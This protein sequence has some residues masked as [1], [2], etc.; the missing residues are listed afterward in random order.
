MDTESKSR[1][2]LLEELEVLRR[3]VAELEAR[4]LDRDR[5]SDRVDLFRRLVEHSLGL[6]CVHDLDGN[7]LFVNTAAAQ[8]LG[9]RPE[10][11]VGWNLRT[12]LPPSVENQFDAYLERIRNNSVDGGLMRLVAK[13]GTERIWLYRNVLYEE[14]GKPPR[15]LGHAQD[16]TER[17]HAQQ[18]LKESEQRFRLLADTAPVL[19]WM[20]DPSGGCAFL[21]QPWLDFTGGALAEQ[22]GVGWT[23]SIHPGDR[24]RF[25]AVYREAVAARTPLQAEF[26]LRRADGEY[27]WV[28]ASGVPRIEADGAFAGLIGSCVDITETR[29]AR[30]VLQAARDELAALVARRTAELEQSNEQLR[31]EMRHRAQIE[32]EVARARRIESLGVLAGGIA[33]EFNNLLTV[34]VGRSQLMLERFPP[35]EPARRD[36][37][38]IQRMTDRAAALTQQL[39]AFGGM[40]VVQPR[41]VNLNKLVAG[42]SLSTVIGERIELTLRL[43]ETLRRAS[44]DPGQLQRV[45]LHLVQN[46]CDA[47]PDGGQLVLETANVD[48]DEAF[49]QTQP[50]A[51]P[52]PHVRL[53]IRD[54][55]AGMDEATRSHVFEPFSTATRG[56]GSELSLAAVYGITKQH[57]GYI[58][59][60]SEPDRGTAFL[61]YL[62]AAGEAGSPAVGMPSRGPRGLGG[63]ETVLLVEDEEDVR[64]LLR[65]I[66]QLHGYR[67]IEVNDPE[68]ALSLVERRPEPIHLVL[69]DVVMGRMSGPGL[70]DRL[71]AVRPGV[72]VLWM[73]GYTAEALRGQGELDAGVALLKKPFTVMS[74]L[75]KVREVLGGA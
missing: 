66:L 55:G 62:P 23:E 41:L 70:A 18:A 17:I 1:D 35:A 52:G 58:A 26:R 21:N 45:I 33:H 38:L 6:M 48:L 22:V 13:Y 39:L 47:M 73:S 44:V 14:A 16:V 63:T 72:K 59:V 30:E 15:V 19:I 65:D 28:L 8:I 36:V 31:A 60:E 12:F 9:F 4:E 11:G 56:V 24:D 25:V 34:I 46:A 68:E 37:D 67:V 40:Q 29:Q 2:Q 71:S 32:E 20:S 64:L 27:R 43:E 49:I 42:L 61:I 53:T 51:R 75:G 69:T 10:D 57:G 3:R 74:L 50:D 5:L 7:L 54:T